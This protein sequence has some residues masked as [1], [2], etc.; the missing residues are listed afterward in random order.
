MTGIATRAPENCYTPMLAVA[1]L[2]IINRPGEARKFSIENYCQKLCSWLF[3]RSTQ[4]HLAAVSAG[5]RFRKLP[6]Y[7]SR[8]FRLGS[9]RARSGEAGTIEAASV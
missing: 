2:N 6:V 4:R 7:L 8:Q 1:F 5:G 9:A 3:I